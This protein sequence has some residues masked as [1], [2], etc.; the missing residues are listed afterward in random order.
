MVTAKCPNGNDAVQ[1]E[2]VGKCGGPRAGAHK[3][4]VD[5]GRSARLLG[6]D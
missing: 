2:W 6:I 3:L 4:D 1:H 5:T